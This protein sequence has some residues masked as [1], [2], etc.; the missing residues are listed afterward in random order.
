LIKKVETGFTTVK[1]IILLPNPNYMMVH[2]QEKNIAVYELTH[3]K[4]LHNKYMHFPSNI[5]KIIV[6]DEDTLIVALEDY[7]IAFQDQL[8]NISLYQGDVFEKKIK[9][10]L[11]PLVQIAENLGFTGNWMWE[12]SIW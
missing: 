4:L 11:S 5:K 1:Q 12:N 3:F 2:S 7:S 8:D 6:A 9:D 10:Q